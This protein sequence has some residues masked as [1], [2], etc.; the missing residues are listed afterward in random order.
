[1]NVLSYFKSIR[2]RLKLK[3]LAVVIHVEPSDL[4]LQSMLSMESRESADQMQQLD[5]IA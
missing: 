4:S 5:C 2:D 1:M 3:E